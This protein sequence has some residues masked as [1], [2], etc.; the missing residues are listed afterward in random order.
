[1]FVDELVSDNNEELKEE[2][3]KLKIQ[4]RE[5]KEII[6]DI[7]KRYKKTDNTYSF[8]AHIWWAMNNKNNYTKRYSSIFTDISSERSRL[9]EMSSSKCLIM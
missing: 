5:L 6:I 2:I 3:I 7:Q 8:I 1:M 4:N 9:S